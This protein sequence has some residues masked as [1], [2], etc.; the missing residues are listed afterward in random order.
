[1]AYEGFGVCL[2]NPHATVG[3]YLSIKEKR[4]KN[5][6][7][8][9]LK[10]PYKSMKKMVGDGG[11]EPSTPFGAIIEVVTACNKHNSPTGKRIPHPKF[12]QQPYNY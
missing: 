10:R 8:S 6:S 11:I 2:A 5:L 9:V 12:A 7:L 4:L 1:M 3:S